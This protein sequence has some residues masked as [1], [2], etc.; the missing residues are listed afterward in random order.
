MPFSVTIARLPDHRRCS[1][2][3]KCW[4]HACQMDGC[5]F[6]RVIVALLMATTLAACSSASS[7]PSTTATTPASATTTTAPQTAPIGTAVHLVDHAIVGGNPWVQGATIKLLG[8]IDP[9]TLAEPIP[10]WMTVAGRGRWVAMRLEV[11]NDGPT[12]FGNEGSP[13]QPTLEFQTDRNFLSSKRAALPLNMVGCPALQYFL[14]RP[15]ATTTGCVSI[16]ISPG[17]SVR[18]LDVVL[19]FSGLGSDTRPIAEW[20]PS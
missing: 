18:T 14:L 4:C 7:S 9:A 2:G 12:R 13:Y 3:P 6:K 15:G 16:Q 17:S 10:S 1:L 11:T 5:V 8:V 19:A 20:T